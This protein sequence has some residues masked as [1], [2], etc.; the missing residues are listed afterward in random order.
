M[1]K[2]FLITGALLGALSVGLGA[3]AAHALKRMTDEATVGVFHTGVEYQFYHA[4]ALL[5]TGIVYAQFPSAWMTRA[6]WGFIIGT[7][8]FSGSLYAIT[9]LKIN[10]GS[11]GP[12][13]VL[14]P[15]GGLFFIYGWVCMLLGFLKR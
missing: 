13:G 15:I 2:T 14:T 11:L 7:V 1:Q 12:A 8:L 5:L 4:L 9:L 10:G 3:F 6:G